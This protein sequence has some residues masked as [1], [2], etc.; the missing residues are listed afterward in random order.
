MARFHATTIDGYTVNIS[1]SDSTFL[2]RDGIE[3][4][5]LDDVWRVEHE[6]SLYWAPLREVAPEL[7]TYTKLY[8]QVILTWHSPAYASA[9]LRHVTS[10]LRAARRAGIV[11][12]FQPK[13]DPFVKLRTELRN[14]YVAGTTANYLDA[15]RRWYQQCAA[16]ELDGFDEEYA[17]YLSGFTIGGNAKG[18]AVLSN[19]PDGGPLSYRALT[20][21][22]NA[23][24]RNVQAHLSG[25]PNEITE[26]ISFEICSLENLLI[27][28]LSLHFGV[29]PGGCLRHRI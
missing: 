24:E 28:W 18:E 16:L 8:I 25:D 14:N 22:Q 27:T 17:T 26:N 3:I 10:C 4:N 23:L 13:R 2:T 15:F 19:D 5:V 9:Q 7:V 11:V 29:Y 1:V 20:L 12:A 21:I 6:L